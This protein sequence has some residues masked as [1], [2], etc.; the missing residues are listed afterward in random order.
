[1]EF[2]VKSVSESDHNNM[3]LSA[4]ESL[5]LTELYLLFD[6]GVTDWGIY[7]ASVNLWFIKTENI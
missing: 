7:V 3:E 5:I 2:M 4:K 6:K 1:M